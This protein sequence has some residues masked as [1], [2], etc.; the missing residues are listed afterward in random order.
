[1]FLVTGCRHSWILDLS[2]ILRKPDFCQ[3]ENKGAD[4]LRSNCEADQRLCFCYTDSTI[5]LLLKSKISSFK[6]FPETVQANLCRSW[7]ETPKTA[8]LVSRLILFLVSLSKVYRKIKLMHVPICHAAV[9]VLCHKRKKNNLS[10]I[11]R[12]ANVLYMRK[13]RRGLPLTR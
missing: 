11:M 1:M 8:F 12:K 13:Q 4:Q 6:P 5:S 9:A 10:H 7:S 2:R 3:C